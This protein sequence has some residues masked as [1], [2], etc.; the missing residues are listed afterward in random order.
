MVWG[1]VLGLA[2]LYL[3]AELGAEPLVRH[4]GTLLLI[5]GVGLLTYGLLM[6][7][8]CSDSPARS[9]AKRAPSCDV[10]ADPRARQGSDKSADGL[11]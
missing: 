9:T 11:G 7:A 8:L 3:R 4:G 6:S 10:W 2:A 1:L 5:A